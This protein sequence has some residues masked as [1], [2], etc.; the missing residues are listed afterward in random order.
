M[1]D[2]TAGR[3]PGVSIYA[4]GTVLLRGGAY[5][6]VARLTPEALDALWS[7]VLADPNVSGD[8][9]APPPDWA[10]GFT[11]YIVQVRDG[12][13]LVSR[14]V[15]NA[16]PADQEAEATAVMAL[17]DRLLALETWLPAEAWAVAPD[18]AEAWV[19]ATY[20]LKIIDGGYVPDMPLPVDVVDIAWPLTEAPTEFG[21]PFDLGYPPGDP[22]APRGSRCGAIDLTTALAIQEALGPVIEYPEDRIPGKERLTV[23][24][25]WAEAGSFLTISLAAQLPDDPADCSADTSWP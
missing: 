8:D 4:D 20:L 1:P 18:D 7:E 13:G 23:D 10:A 12:D 9:I 11:S 17:V 2:V 14:R 5:G 24:L 6:L 22:G 16:Y 25:A 15:A 3:I 19:P 21:D